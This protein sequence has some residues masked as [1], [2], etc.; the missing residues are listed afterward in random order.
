MRFNKNSSYQYFGNKYE[1]NYDLQEILTTEEMKVAIH[2]WFGVT[3]C[4]IEKW[5]KFQN[6]EKKTIY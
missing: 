5:V 6:N 2:N 1:E 3:K 4:S